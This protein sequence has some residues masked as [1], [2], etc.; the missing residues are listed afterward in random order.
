MAI[1]R[2]DKEDADDITR[3]TKTSDVI[4]RRG[5]LSKIFGGGRFGV[6]KFSMRPII[7]KKKE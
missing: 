1:E 5:R 6:G 2:K 7:R 3:E 4:T